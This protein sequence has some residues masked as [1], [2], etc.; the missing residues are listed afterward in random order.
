MFRSGRIVMLGE[1]RLYEFLAEIAGV[2]PAKSGWAELEFAPRLR[3]Y[4]S[5]KATVPFQREGKMALAIVEWTTSGDETRVSLR[6]EGLISPLLVHVKLQGQS[7][8]VVESSK[9]MEFSC[10][11]VIAE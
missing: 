3:L 6:I 5:M 10:P 11:K 1:V 8:V 4:P 7:D 9:K 2:R